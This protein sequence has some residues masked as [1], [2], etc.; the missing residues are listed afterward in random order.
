MIL[1]LTVVPQITPYHCFPACLQSYLGEVGVVVSQNEIVSRCSTAHNAGKKE[2]GA[3]ILQLLDDVRKEFSLS[4]VQILAPSLAF[5]HPKQSMF[6]FAFWDGDPGQF[7]CVRLAGMDATHV[8][9]MNPKVSGAL[10]K[11][12]LTKF[13]AWGKMLMLVEKK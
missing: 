1:P 4:I 11:V 7:H 10:D 5:S 3:L 12:D 9:L 2:E 13:E 6:I 8:H